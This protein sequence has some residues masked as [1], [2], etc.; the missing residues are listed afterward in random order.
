G[1]LAGLHRRALPGVLARAAARPRP[2]GRPAAPHHPPPPRPPTP[3]PPPPRPA[4]P[5]PPPPPA[6]P[7]PPPS[8]PPPPPPPATLARAVAPRRTR[9][10]LSPPGSTVRRHAPG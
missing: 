5:H 3:P 1:P 9:F 10:T 6:R 4:P 7:R 8:P 2:A